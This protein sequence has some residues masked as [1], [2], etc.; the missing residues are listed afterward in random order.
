MDASAG[1]KEVR[2]VGVLEFN[3]LQQVGE[4]TA[5]VE[6]QW[7]AASTAQATRKAG[8]ELQSGGK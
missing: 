5:E 7:Q 4:G 8:A 3:A 6:G 2:G 1:E